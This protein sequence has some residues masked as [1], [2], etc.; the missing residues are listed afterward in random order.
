M[1]KIKSIDIP[2]E[3]FPLMHTRVFVRCTYPGGATFKP[4]LLDPGSCMIPLGFTI[5]LDE[6]RLQQEGNVSITRV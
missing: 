2:P 6:W 1:R 4:H 5:R 3:Q